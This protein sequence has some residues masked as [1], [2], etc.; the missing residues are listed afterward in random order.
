MNLNFNVL[1]S[2]LQQHIFNNNRLVKVVKILQRNFKFKQLHNG[3]S[4]D[5]KDCI[6]NTALS[7]LDKYKNYTPKQIKYLLQ[8]TNNNYNLNKINNVGLFTY[9]YND[10]DLNRAGSDIMAT[11][12]TEL[13]YLDDY[14]DTQRE[15]LMHYNQL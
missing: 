14:L 9:L 7:M 4:D 2:E 3:L 6:C 1:P 15:V 5:G 11:L 10:W 12:G 13:T 8:I